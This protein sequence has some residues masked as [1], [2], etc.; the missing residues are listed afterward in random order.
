MNLVDKLNFDEKGLI[1]AV[2]QDDKTGKVLTLCYMDKAALE[3]TQ[4]RPC[5]QASSKLKA[6]PDATA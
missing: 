4:S 6:Q 5:R 1:P 2:I 3:K